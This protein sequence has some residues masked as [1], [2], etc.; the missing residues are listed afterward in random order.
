MIKV[1]KNPPAN[2]I[3]EH[4]QKI[5]FS[6]SI[7]N[8]KT[9]EVLA[10]VKFRPYLFRMLSILSDHFELIVFTSADSIYAHAALD[11]IEQKQR[12]F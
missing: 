7:G 3:P 1:I 10:Y 6:Y 4:D 5:T 12:Y 2:M 9:I 8:E 11:A